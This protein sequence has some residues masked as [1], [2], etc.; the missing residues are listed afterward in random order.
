MKNQDII[1]Q[2][3]LL[4]R[5]S[6]VRGKLGW[7]V[8]RNI[9]ILSDACTE[10]MK[11]R[12]EAV[13]K[14]GSEENGAYSINPSSEHWAEYAAEVEPVMNIEQDVKLCKISRAEFDDIAKDADLTAA[15]L[16]V[17]DEILVEETH[18]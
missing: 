11:I 15:E 18:E 2:A 5:L 10:A 17:L 6:G 4:K 12:N 16:M 13:M 1:M 14:Y 9:K 3:E 7:Y 8:Y